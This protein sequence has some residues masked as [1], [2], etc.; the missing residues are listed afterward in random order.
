M[1]TLGGSNGI[2]TAGRVSEFPPPVSGIE[3]VRGLLADISEAARSARAPS[4]PIRP[5]APSEIM[6][7][8]SEELGAPAFP[9]VGIGSREALALVTRIAV[10]YGVDLSNPLA[11]GHLHPPA[12]PTAAAADVLANVTNASVDTYDAGPAAIGMERWLVKALANAAGLGE[13]GDGVLTPGGSVSNLMGLLLAR[14]IV[15]SRHGVDIRKCGVGGLPGMVVLCSEAAHVSLLK[16]CATLGLGEAAVI[17]VP[18]DIRWRMTSKS[19]TRALDSLRGDQIPVA[20]VA[21]AGTTNFGSVDPMSEIAEVAAENSVWMHVDAAYGFGLRFSNTLSGLLDGMEKADSITLD[22]NKFGWQPT[23]SSA[24][25]VADS[26][27]FA[28]LARQVSYINPVDE[29][30]AGYDGLLG[31]SLQGTR[32]ADAMKS[33]ATM[34]AYGMSDLGKMVDDCVALAKYAERRILAEKE[35]EL[36]AHAEL[37]VV[38]FR[39]RGDGFISDDEANRRVRRVLLESGQAILG[40]ADVVLSYLRD[41]PQVCLKLTFVNPRTT[42]EDVD[43]LLDLVKEALSTSKSRS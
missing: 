16:S 2:R 3:A 27:H 43:A 40:R 32:R 23:A 10:E 39:C 29:C 17:P 20:V 33:I 26:A 15:A 13:A 25:L 11:A 12:L 28:P 18:T 42:F 41:Q 7:A 19:L 8:V 6:K 31:R 24:L 22:L 21:T 37:S 9:D 36:V 14:D 35:L 4:G 34:M 5:G 30:V 1:S 38:L